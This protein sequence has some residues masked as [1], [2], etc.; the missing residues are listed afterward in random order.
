MLSQMILYMY[1]SACKQASDGEFS[2]MAC[3]ADALVDFVVSQVLSGRSAR[4]YQKKLNNSITAAKT[5][6]MVNMCND[7]NKAVEEETIIERDLFDLF[8]VKLDNEETNIS[9]KIEIK[10][11]LSRNNLNIESVYNDTCT[12]SKINFMM[13]DE[14]K[15]DLSNFSYT[16][17]KKNETEI[18]KEKEASKEFDP[19]FA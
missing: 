9:D 14:G 6:I 3:A 18:K 12:K 13:N 2:A 17:E 4:F 5:M 10:Y 11:S 16:V 15:C 7:W 8:S 19:S 1:N